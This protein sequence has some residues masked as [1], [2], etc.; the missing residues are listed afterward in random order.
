MDFLQEEWCR[1]PA[2]LL[3][4]NGRFNLAEFLILNGRFSPA[5]FHILNDYL[6]YSIHLQSSPCFLCLLE[7][8]AV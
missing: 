7:Y 5:E 1:V 8:H 6:W 4:L 2:E 3:A